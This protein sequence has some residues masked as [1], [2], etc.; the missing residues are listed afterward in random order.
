[1]VF[2]VKLMICMFGYCCMQHILSRRAGTSIYG[3]F[4]QFKIICSMFLL[5]SITR[6]LELGL[7]LVKHKED[8]G[9]S[10][11]NNYCESICWKSW[12]L[13]CCNGFY[14]FPTDVR[15][16]NWFWKCTWFR[17]KYVQCPTSIFH[18]RFLP[19]STPTLPFASRLWKYTWFRLRCFHS[20]TSLFQCRFSPNL[21]STL[22]VYYDHLTKKINGIH[23]KSKN[24]FAYAMTTEMLRRC[25]IIVFSG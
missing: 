9:K 13:F 1:V 2:L 4:S 19:N 8:I 7:S 20:P 24:L 18:D 21:T 15:F 23:V 17:F 11:I 10:A 3:L 12:K 22:P 5:V 6:K 14:D 25:I 16:A